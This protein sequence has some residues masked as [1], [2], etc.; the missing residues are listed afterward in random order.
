MKLIDMSCN[1][2]YYYLVRAYKLLIALWYQTVAPPAA[3]ELSF[4]RAT[5]LADGRS[6]LLEWELLH[7][8]GPSITAF[9]VEVRG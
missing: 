5:A 8:G 1:K 6:L 3:P 9:T 2:H 4:F 7:D